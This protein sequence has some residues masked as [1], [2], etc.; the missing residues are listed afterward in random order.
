[1]ATH[2]I[3]ELYKTDS[4][5]EKQGKPFLFADGNLRVTLARAG[6]GNQ[7]Y[8]KILTANAKPYRRAIQAELISPDKAQEILM[9]T[10]AE[11][12]VQKW[13]TLITQDDGM[14]DFKEG[15]LLEGMEGL[16]P[17]NIA[18]IVKLFKTLPELF[19]EVQEEAN[20]LSN[21]QTYER[22]EDV[23]N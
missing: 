5:L 9:A 3:Y 13:E 16:Q 6:G 11:A 21:Y 1:M 14:G 23:K 15:I 7:R 19:R 17:V 2:S 18:N 8:E 22:E 10:Y 20:K 4:T 12:I